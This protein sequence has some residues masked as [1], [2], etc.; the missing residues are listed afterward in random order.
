MKLT[1]NFSL[2][3]FK[4]RDGSEVPPEYMENVRELS[5][6]LQ[7]LRDYIGKPIIVISGYRSL[8]Y[9]TKIDG[10]KKSQHLK[11]RAAD[12]VIAG[13]KPSEVK[14]AILHLIDSGKM[15][16]GGI[17]Q[18]T[19]FVHYDVRGYKSRW[20]GSGVKKEDQV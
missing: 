5:K 8:E 12:I 1:D 13:M 15:K 6:N 11:A 4:C 9:N 3:E 16:Q 17:G 18:Y 19:T 2:D 14:L 10:A 7:V 20:Y